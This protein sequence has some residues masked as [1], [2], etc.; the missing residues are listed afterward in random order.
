VSARAAAV[1]VADHLAAGGISLQWLTVTVAEIH[2]VIGAYRMLLHARAV[3]VAVDEIGLENAEFIGAWAEEHRAWIAREGAPLSALE[4]LDPDPHLPPTREA[5]TI[6]AVAE[7]AAVRGGCSLAETIWIG[8]CAAEQ[9]RLRLCGGE[10]DP[11]RILGA[12]PLANAALGVLGEA[13]TIGL[14]ALVA[15]RFDGLVEV[16]E[17]VIA[18]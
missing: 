1:A 12:D 11:Q 10:P 18:G 2:R 16:A 4:E 15:E 9:W 5:V 7:S 14:A 13:R 17:A 3:N 8:V 6:C